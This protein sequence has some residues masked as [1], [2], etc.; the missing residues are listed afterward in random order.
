M[1]L[2]LVA[3]HIEPGPRA[4]P[5]GPGMLAAALKK[6]HPDHVQTTVVDLFL[7]QSAEAC[8]DALLALERWYHDILLCAAGAGESFFIHGDR[9]Q[10]VRALATGLTCGRACHNIRVIEDM[11]GQVDLNVSE[12]MLFDR[13]FAVLTARNKES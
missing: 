5:L 2:L 12:S 8:A 1:H 11:K 7:N 10:S 3:L 9:A 13:A 4:V 6:H